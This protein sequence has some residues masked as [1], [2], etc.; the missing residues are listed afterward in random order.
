VTVG[1]SLTF[2]TTAA[3]LAG[4]Y[5]ALGP[6]DDDPYAA[7]AGPASIVVTG[8]VQSAAAEGSRTTLTLEG[9]GGLRVVATLDDEAD[10]TAA[11]ALRP[12]ATVALFSPMRPTF[13]R[14]GKAVE[15]SS[16]LLAEP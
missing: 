13:D 12:G 1:P 9:A 14:G 8:V 16:C 4:R 5:A 2:R 10:Q 15:L 11:A 7:P 3:E 6:G